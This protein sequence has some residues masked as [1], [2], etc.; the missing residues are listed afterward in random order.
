MLCTP[1]GALSQC[2]QVLMPGLASN[3]PT[4]R[5]GDY[6]DEDARAGSQHFSLVSNSKIEYLSFLLRRIIPQECYHK[7][8][9]KASVLDV[10]VNKTT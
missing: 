5:G 6:S 1:F 3:T 8:Q 9:F 2:I 7:Q 10:M 4:H